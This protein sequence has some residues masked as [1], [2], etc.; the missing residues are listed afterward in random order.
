MNDSEIKVSGK[1]REPKGKI[2]ALIVEDDKRISRFIEINA[3]MQSIE[4]QSAENAI[5]AI[6]ILIKAKQDK[7]PIDFVITDLK[8]VGGDLGGF[9]VAE[10]VKGSNLAKFVILFTANENARRLTPEKLK[11][12]GIDIFIEKPAYAQKLVEG[13][14]K[15]K[16]AIKS[17]SANQ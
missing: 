12:K 1:E 7:K 8:L 11:E 13:F 16:K 10:A 6:G 2:R 17:S 15:A 3:H 9:E 5:D 4:T 14:N